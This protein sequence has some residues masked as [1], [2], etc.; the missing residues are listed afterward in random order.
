VQARSD[1]GSHGWL[2]AG[3]NSMS[4]NLVSE[5][6]ILEA[7]HQVPPN[8]WREVLDF[9]DTLRFRQ[10][11]G[12]P[13]ISL[14]ATSVW[15]AE[16]LRHYERAI[17]NTILHTQVCRLIEQHR[18]NPEPKTAISWWT[19]Q[20]IRKLPQEQQDIVLEASA[21]IAAEEYATNPELTAFEA[22]GKDDVLMAARSRL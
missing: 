14:L 17:Q 4:S 9:L 16:D 2:Q 13:D 20:E 1:L 3:K 18:S 21:T 11:G 6:Q 10:K 22:F 15:T 12:A 7:L 5:R 19:A 8:R